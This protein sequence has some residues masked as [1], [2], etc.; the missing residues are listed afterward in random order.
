MFGRAFSLKRLV[1][2]L[3]VNFGSQNVSPFIGRALCNDGGI[4]GFDVAVRFR[5]RFVV[6]DLFRRWRFDGWR[7]FGRSLVRSVGTDWIRQS[8]QAV[9]GDDGDELD[10]AQS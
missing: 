10:E 6:F 8:G 7:S 5:L 2:G 4:V 3:F 1:F 9:D